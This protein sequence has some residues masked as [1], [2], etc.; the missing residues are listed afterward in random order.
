MA[1]QAIQLDLNE[2]CDSF[3]PYTD[4]SIRNRSLRGN[5]FGN[6]ADADDLSARPLS[7]CFV[8]RFPFTLGG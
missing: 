3:L 2:F 8:G 7:E 5:P 6:L 1:K 4:R